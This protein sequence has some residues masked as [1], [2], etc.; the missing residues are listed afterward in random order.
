LNVV[1]IIQARIGS[2][3]L[4]GKVLKK[5]Q[6]KVVL[7]Y[8]IDRLKTCKNV[9]EIVLAIPTNKNDDS[10]ETYAKNKKINF[11]R[12]SEEDVL[13][14]YYEAAKKFNAEVIVRIT[15]D[16][17]LIDP[18]IVDEIVKKHLENKA[19]YSANIITR[20]FP[21]GLDAE[22]FNFDTLEDCYKHG[23]K[24]YHRE[25]VTPYIMEHPEKFKLQNIEAPVKLK[26][27]DIRITVDTKEDFEL[28]S[29]IINHFDNLDFKTEDIVNFLETNPDLMK[30]NK[31]VKQKEFKQKLK[32]A[33]RVDASP[34]IGMGHLMRCLA[35]SEELI[36]RGHACFFV[37]KIDNDELIDRIEKNNVHFQIDSNANLREDAETLVKFSNENDIDWIITDHYG[38]DSAYIENI[39]ENNF[40]V[41][42][43]DDTAQIHYFSDV[44]LNQNI[45]SEKLKYS[46]EK[47]TKF[48][49]G[50]KY[51]ILRDQFLAKD[52]RSKTNDVKK[53]LVMLGG[54]DKDNLVLKIIKSL[55]SFNKK[56]EFLVVIGPLNIHY[57]E[58]KTFAEKEKLKIRL[59]KSP[60]DMADLY[61]ESDIAISAGGTS[62]YEMAYF[63]I[64]NII[65]SIADNQ[66]AIS[67]EFDEQNISIYLG[68]KEEITSDQLKNKFKELVDNPS[69]RKKMSEN[70]NKLVDGKG[71]QRIIDFVEKI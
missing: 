47:H 29:K 63:G 50:P 33:F 20:T 39:K 37:S 66:L 70:G 12:G 27:P 17:P 54:T 30:I 58:I 71:K 67:N 11:I 26:R 6:D 34:D 16:C 64:P 13:S 61:L 19:D 48:L 23:N 65:I 28:I 2:T 4:P 10:L 15:S 31:H 5:I 14:R 60:E 36:R 43:V 7:D 32:V 68:K 51:A 53:I 21:H 69:L 49:L 22:V 40:N 55:K 18:D 42:S 24:K 8:V 35:L 3:R 9:D 44:V 25:H 38:I 62:C 57:D 1:A 56:I 59:I 45:G 41:L 46:T 52:S